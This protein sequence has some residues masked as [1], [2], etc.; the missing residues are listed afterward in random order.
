VGLFSKLWAVRGIRHQGL[1]VTD[2]AP[3]TFLHKGRKSDL[4]C[5]C[6]VEVRKQRELTF[7]LPRNSVSFCTAARRLG[8]QSNVCYRA[9]I[10][11]K[12]EYDPD[13]LVLCPPTPY[14]Y[15]IFF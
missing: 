7:I 6:E 10:Q 12:L 1:T 4:R 2:A 11:Y 3:C 8:A 14:R 13:C 15:S 9:Y 5:K